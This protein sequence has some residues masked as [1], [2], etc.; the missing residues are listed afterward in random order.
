MA[1]E[2]SP[3]RTA[4]KARARAAKLSAFIRQEAADKGFDL[5]RITGPESIPQAPARLLEFVDAGYHGTMAWME[6]TRE[7]RG[8]PKVLWP[9]VRSIVMFG[10][11]YGPET[12]PRALQA[13]PDKAAISVYARNRDYHDIIKGK[14]KEIATRF[15][16]RAGEDVK[17]F[18]D[19]APVMEKPLAAAAGLGWQGKHTNLVSRDYGSWLFLGSLFTTAELELDTPER[20]HCGSCRACLDACPTAAFPAPYQIDAR[21][22]I[23]YLTIEHK[24]VIDR[25]LR[26]AFGN[27]IY[28]CDDC[29]AACPWN[30]FAA[31]AREIKLQAREDLTAPDIAFLLTLDDPGFRSHFSGSPVKR[32]GRD[33][34][35]RN[36]LIAAGN[37]G[38]ST[39][40][41]P[42]LDLLADASPDVRGMAVWALSRLMPSQAFRALAHYRENEPDSDVRAEWIAAGV[43]P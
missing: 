19:T 35:V 8:D 12:D 38:L 29:L 9:Q 42:C 17:V 32:I 27:R 34:F 14:L 37:S 15:A 13:Q 40:I 31:Q 24:G 3:E 6:E 28:G 36:V 7:R 33:R 1:K 20:D 4:E 11:N 26:P 5:C 18:V 43:T 41:T 23:S 10:L 21:R 30:K 16:A 22:C 39:L 25:D 2:G